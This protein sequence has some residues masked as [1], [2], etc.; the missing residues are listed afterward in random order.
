MLEQQH[1][2]SRFFTVHVIDGVNDLLLGPRADFTLVLTKKEGAPSSFQRSRNIEPAGDLK[3]IAAQYPRF[4]F[5]HTG[6]VYCVYRWSDRR[7]D[8][9]HHGAAIMVAHKRGTSRQW[10]SH[11]RRCGEAGGV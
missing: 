10:Q 11:A 9:P 7:K 5:D 3:T 1:R 8:S 6:H 4:A 2:L